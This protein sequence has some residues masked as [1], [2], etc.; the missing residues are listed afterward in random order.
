MIVRIDLG[1]EQN[2]R[3]PQCFS[4]VNITSNVRARRWSQKSLEI[5]NVSEDPEN[6]VFP[7]K[8]ASVGIEIY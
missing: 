3:N 6:E 2:D 8:I 1:P 5:D 7:K 4:K